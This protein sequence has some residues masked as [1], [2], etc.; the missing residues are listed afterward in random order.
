M[1]LIT[2]KY[3]P[4]HIISQKNV[5][6][7]WSDWD[8]YE[9]IHLP[10][11]GTMTVLSKVSNRGVTAFAIGCAEWVV[12]RFRKLSSDK[13]PYDFLESCWVL[14][15][16]NEYVQPEGMEE[17]EWK[18]PIRGAIDL[19]LLTIVNTWNVSEYGSAE[20]EG[21]FAAQIALLVLQDK[22]LFLDWQEKV[23]Q[24]LIKYYPRDEEAPDGPPVPREVL[25]PSVDLETV[26]SDQLIKAFLSKVDYK[27]N[28]F[29]KDI[30]P[31]GFTDSA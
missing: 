7:E 23:L 4:I 29:L 12:Y 28:P 9:K 16:G 25:Y 17:S 27:S 14:V 22:S 10:N 3:I 1:S 31:A 11:E 18:G 13:T 19:A 26:Q 5:Q 2:P 24:R 21:G 6:H 20:Q 15:M 8:P 30:E